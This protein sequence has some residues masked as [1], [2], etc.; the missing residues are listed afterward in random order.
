MIMDNETNNYVTISGM[1]NAGAPADTDIIPIVRNSSNKTLTIGAIKEHIAAPL[2]DYPFEVT[3][4]RSATG[5]QW[6]LNRLLPAVITAEVVEHT[7]RSLY[8][9]DLAYI[10]RISDSWAA[11]NASQPEFLKQYYNAVMLGRWSRT[12][13][14][15]EPEF[16]L[17]RDYVDIIKGGQ[18]KFWVSHDWDGTQVRV[19][20]DA[21]KLPVDTALSISNQSSSDLRGLIH[22][23]D[24]C[25]RYESPA[26]G[27]T[28]ANME[29]VGTGSQVAKV[30][31]GELYIGAKY[32]AAR[33]ITMH[34]KK[35]MFNEL[36]TFYRVGLA[37]NNGRLPA[38]NPDRD[39]AVTLNSA[40]YSDN[41]GPLLVEGSTWTGGNHPYTDNTTK[42]AKT[43]SYEF[44]AD[45]LPLS[46]G[47]LV[48]ADVVTVR[49][50]NHIYDPRVAPSAGATHLSRL[51]CVETVT[52]RIEGGDIQVSVNHDYTG[53]TPG[54]LSTYHGMQSMCDGETQILT[55]DGA[56]AS[57][58]TAATNG[59]QFL[60]SAYPD[61]RRILERRADGNMQLTM[62][63]PDG[64]GDHRHV[65][66][67]QPV[68]S[69]NSQKAYHYLLRGY[70]FTASSN[71]S[72]RGLYS[73]MPW[74]AEVTGGGGALLALAYAD[75]MDRRIYVDVTESCSESLT[76]PVPSDAAC[77]HMEVV[78]GDDVVPALDATAGT[79]RVTG[80]DENVSAVIDY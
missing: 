14:G 6:L 18:G 8:R 35:C 73:W 76:L 79:I 12:N 47:D 15:A 62:L 22:I 50:T 1:P 24:T 64:I 66:A 26:E 37:A 51:L 23:A 16:V 31:G 54:K 7:T 13:P 28:V 56:Y 29:A 4:D 77:R 19:L 61:F 27:E 46:D 32:D 25:H 34:F 65:G 57:G 38:E 17:L 74:R 40:R 2:D 60:K 68:F 67:T 48:R 43:V 5:V 80:I 11:A 45:G 9:Y 53:A 39:V 63:Y 70:N 44:A 78:S 42:T 10:S 21:S 52:Y 49:V 71:Y 41:I 59:M 33:D 20:I 3:A 30:V 75:R 55:P 36:L 72:W 69:Y 58:W